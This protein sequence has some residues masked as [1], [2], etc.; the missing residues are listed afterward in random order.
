MPKQQLRV[1]LQDEIP[2]NEYLKIEKQKSPQNFL[3]IALDKKPME[4]V[5]ISLY[6]NHGFLSVVFTIPSLVDL[7]LLP[8]WRVELVLSA[9]DA[10]TIK[11]YCLAN[12][13]GKPYS[14][15]YGVYLVVHPQMTLIASV[16]DNEKKKVAITFCEGKLYLFLL[17]KNRDNEEIQ[18]GY[19][20]VASPLAL[21][22]ISE[23]FVSVIFYKN[24]CTKPVTLEELFP[25]DPKKV[26]VKIKNPNGEIE[27]Q[28]VEDHILYEAAHKWLQYQRIWSM[29]L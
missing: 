27:L 5:N 23:A 20:Q 4:I 22:Y 29:R 8:F 19:I 18:E 6:Y 25:S 12:R 24:L 16:A 14:L 3:A 21:K 2:R 17:S 10:K 7:G 11:V 26:F 28:K 9:N 13:R 1:H 15:D